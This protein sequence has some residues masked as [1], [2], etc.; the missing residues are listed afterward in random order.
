LLT[1]VAL[2]TP[3]AVKSPGARKVHR[4]V[5]SAIVTAP[6]APPP[7]VACGSSDPPDVVAADWLAAGVEPPLQ[8]VM[9]ATTKRCEDVARKV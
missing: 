7:G 1:S 4:S 6:D 3:A 5:P 8:A 2:P 9:M